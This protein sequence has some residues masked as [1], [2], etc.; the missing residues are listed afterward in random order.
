MSRSASCILLL[1]SNL[2]KS[3]NHSRIGLI[4]QTLHVLEYYKNPT[5]KG[6]WLGSWNNI[7]ITWK[8]WLYKLVSMSKKLSLITPVQPFQCTQ[9]W[10]LQWTTMITGN[11]LEKKQGQIYSFRI[12]IENSY[13]IQKETSHFHGFFRK[14]IH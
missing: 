14:K 9:S 12:W 13:L 7:N 10:A 2:E 6:K 11:F 3:S 4:N 8:K 5:T 1:C